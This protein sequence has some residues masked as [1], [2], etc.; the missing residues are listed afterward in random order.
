MGGSWGTN[1]RGYR[2]V[3]VQR[4]G[5]IRTYQCNP[6]AFYVNAASFAGP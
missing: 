2:I 6:Q 5:R 1:Y 4:E 3:E